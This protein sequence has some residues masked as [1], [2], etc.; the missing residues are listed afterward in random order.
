MT[1]LAGGDPVFRLDKVTRES[2][3]TTRM[4]EL[5]GE[6]DDTHGLNPALTVSLQSNSEYLI[7]SWLFHQGP[8]VVCLSM[9]DQG[10]DLPTNCTVVQ[11]VDPA[12][13]EEQR[14]S[15]EP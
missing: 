15:E 3:Q 6:D 8:G 11:T 2:E 13:P 1:G 7:S 9:G 10:S 14:E 4:C 12:P 5:I